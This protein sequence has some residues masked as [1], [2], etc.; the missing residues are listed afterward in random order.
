M[1][2][3]SKFTKSEWANGQPSLEIAPYEFSMK[4]F[5]RMLT[6]LTDYYALPESKIIS[7][8][9]KIMATLKIKDEV[10]EVDMD[11]STCSLAFK[12]AAL[13]DEVF[14]LFKKSL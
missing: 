9:E 4:G 8:A 6:T 12:T 14:T 3:K 13:R 11:T 2:S 7:G 5:L 1:N 10:V